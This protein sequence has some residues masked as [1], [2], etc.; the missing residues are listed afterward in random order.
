MVRIQTHGRKTQ[1]L[2]ETTQTKII[3]HFLG[4]TITSWFVFMTFIH[5]ILNHVDNNISKTFTFSIQRMQR[6]SL[7][8][9]MK[10]VTLFYFELWWV[11]FLFW[12]E[13]TRFFKNIYV[14][15]QKFTTCQI[16][17]LKKEKTLHQICFLVHFFSFC[18]FFEILLENIL[19][20]PQTLF[21]FSN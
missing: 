19:L 2:F 17:K 18:N 20:P 16:K 12:G 6:K 15:Q 11:F 9:N 13:K 14:L 8:N 4:I 3:F 1:N 7:I 5:V 10:W 21:F